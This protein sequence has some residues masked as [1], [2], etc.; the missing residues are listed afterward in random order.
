MRSPLALLAAL[1]LSSLCL[2]ALAA[3]NVDGFK[4]PAEVTVAD[5][6]VKVRDYDT[7]AIDLDTERTVYSTHGVLH[8]GQILSEQFAPFFEALGMMM[9]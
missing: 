1:S 6:D 5:A 4:P 9:K 7:E 3:P 2:S 8:E